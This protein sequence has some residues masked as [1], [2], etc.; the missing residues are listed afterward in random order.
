M[1][2]TKQEIK[3]SKRKESREAIKNI[4]TAD[5]IIV[6]ISLIGGFGLVV[7]GIWFS[8]Y[9]HLVKSH[10]SSCGDWKLN[11]GVFTFSLGD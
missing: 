7:I 5:W 10:S 8:S 9:R 6:G 3:N 2:W 4:T 11:L 1:N